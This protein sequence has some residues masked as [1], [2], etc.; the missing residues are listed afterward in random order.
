MQQHRALPDVFSHGIVPSI[1]RLRTSRR[2][3]RNPLFTYL[4]FVGISLLLLGS[5]AIG[6]LGA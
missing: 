4:A 1:P 3:R 5:I 2:L 6:S